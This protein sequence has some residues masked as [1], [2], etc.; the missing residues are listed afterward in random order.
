MSEAQRQPPQPD[1]W[2]DEEGR[3]EAQK[4][5]RSDVGASL[6]R[7]RAE[8]EPSEDRVEPTGQRG[9]AG[10]GQVAG[11]GKLGQPTDSEKGAEQGPR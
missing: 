9:P 4:G 1:D 11:R 10:A 8:D 7:P 6:E 2:P 5:L 3:G